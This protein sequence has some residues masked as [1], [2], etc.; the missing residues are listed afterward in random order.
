MI[1]RP[2]ARGNPVVA[3]SG[4]PDG[5]DFTGTGAG[6]GRGLKEGR[7]GRSFRVVRMKSDFRGP[8]S[9]HWRALAAVLATAGALPGGQLSA[10]PVS[11]SREVLPVLS[12]NCFSCHGPD[13]KHR[14]AGLRLDE[15][16]DAKAERDGV[17]AIVP[18]DPDAS[19]LIRRIETA[20]PDLRM[21]PAEFHKS[22]PPEQIATL[23]RWIAEGAEWGVHWAFSPIERP[24]VPAEPGAHP[25]DAFLATRLARENL[26]PRPEADRR[27]LLRRASL[28]LTGLPPTPEEVERFVANPAADA[29]EQEI[30]RLLASPAY[31]ERMAWDWME[32]AR[33]ADTNGY[34]G[35][36][37]RTMWPWRDWVVR[38]FNANLP[39]DR[40][41]VWQLAGD[42]LPDATDEQRLATGF[43]RN[44]PINGEGGRIP[45]ENRVDYAM[46]MAETT[47][48]VWLG[49][50]LNCC[51]CHD[52]KFDPLTQRDYYSLLAYFNQTPVDGSGG[53]PQTP[54]V[55]A[56]PSPE[57]QQALAVAD[58]EIADLQKRFEAAD[59][60]VQAGGAGEPEIE[61]AGSLRR[62]LEEAKKAR[63]GLWKSVPKVMVMADRPEPRKTWVLDHGLYNKPQDE[64]T[65]AVP[66]SLPQ[67]PPGTP[68]DRAG[69]A[70]WIVSPDNPLTARVAANRLW[71]MLFGIGIVKT[72]EDFGVQAEF[73][74]HPELLDW[75]A[76]E[77]RDSG[78]NVKHLLRTIMT[79]GAY[80]R[81][82]RTTPELL[83]RDPDNRLLAR[84]P[85]FRM[86]SWMI[87]DNAL[88]VSG[89]LVPV[90]GGPPVRPWQPPGVWEEATFGNVKYVR[91]TGD[92]LY[93]RSLYTFW[94]RIVGPTMF[95]DSPSRSVCTVKPVRTNTPLHALTTLNDTAMVEAA[96]ALAVRV[97]RA[98]SPPRDRIGRLFQF[99]LSRDPKESEATVLLAGLDRSTARF[100]ADPEAA[101]TFLTEGEYRAPE[102]IDPVECAAWTVAALT[103]LNLDETITLE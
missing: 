69:L 85:R 46:D 100:A 58:A 17:R 87:R 18:G 76:A 29:W 32:A 99:A 38:A 48:T 8:R 101:R 70:A 59:A 37:E 5:R 97:L 16:S 77:F 79:S 13:E 82:S 95:F 83:E 75:L 39:W 84:G 103:I 53:D 22:V 52:H 47:G 90:S 88:A 63:E 45:E 1:G 3:G 74:V 15:E 11:F 10:A 98:A 4:R 56:V 81:S 60:L 26:E 41:T 67:P 49:L 43:L 23:R 25:V 35:D 54:P 31:G 9:R 6:G 51:R 92:G 96:R 94:R 61:E 30:D 72:A 86:P 57:Q 27:T 102:D 80:R 44:H 14:K 33:Y 78:W 73:P 91:S 24:P 93:R 34:Q 89:L 62:L 65:A 64:V 12:D 55:L 36:A 66:A 68:P 42:L 28:D 50:T 2:A 19:D 40:F 7:T 71:Q 20:D 21:P